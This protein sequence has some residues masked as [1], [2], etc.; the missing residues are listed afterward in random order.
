[1]A[2]ILNQG[3]HQAGA[4]LPS[5]NDNPAVNVEAAQTVTEGEACTA[6]FENQTSTRVSMPSGI[7]GFGFK[8]Q[9]KLPI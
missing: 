6:A 1:M 7:T 2:A 5:L 4:K 9:E 8:V 3:K